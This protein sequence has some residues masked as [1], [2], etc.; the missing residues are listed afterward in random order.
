MARARTALETNPGDRHRHISDAWLLTSGNN[1]MRGECRVFPACSRIVK[2]AETPDI[3][4]KGDFSIEL[5]ENRR[6]DYIFDCVNR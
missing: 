5:Q 3:T 1:A 4:Q 6:Q 2:V